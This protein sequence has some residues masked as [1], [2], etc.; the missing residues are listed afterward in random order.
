LVDWIKIIIKTIMNHQKKHQ[1]IYYPILMKTLNNGKIENLKI[2]FNVSQIKKLD[3]Q[4]IAIIPKRIWIL[5]NLN[6]ML[7]V[8]EYTLLMDI[9]IFRKKRKYLNVKMIWKISLARI[10]IKISIYSS[11]WKGKWNQSI[12][13][14]WYKKK[15]KSFS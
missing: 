15:L 4:I 7:W 12:L 8:E 2:L 6:K 10:Q 11:I 3:N 9:V 13:V 14:K 1:P 5:K